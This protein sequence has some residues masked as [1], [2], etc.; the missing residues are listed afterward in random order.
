VLTGYTGDYTLIQVETGT[1]AGLD[2]FNLSE[3]KL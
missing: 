2:Y 1:F 3:E